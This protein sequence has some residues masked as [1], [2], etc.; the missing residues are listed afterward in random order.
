MSERHVVARTDEIP[1]G[2]RLK[3][4]VRGQDVVIFNVAGEYLAVLDRCPHQGASLCDGKQVGLVR[5]ERPGEL[6]YTRKGEI[7]RCPWHGWEFDL[8]TGKSYCDPR[9]TW[10][11]SYPASSEHG[12]TILE[13]PYIAE[14]FEVLVEDDYLVI[15]A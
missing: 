14:T 8:R 4:R 1:E 2:G 12:A 10:V 11:K 15:D 13:G 6:E 7:V 3:V 9:R 5:S